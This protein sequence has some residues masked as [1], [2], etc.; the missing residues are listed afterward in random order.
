[1]VPSL[2]VV[3]AEIGG[4]PGQAV[5]VDRGTIV[6]VGDTETVDRRGAEVVD[7]GGG[8]LLP[9]LHDHHLHL[10]GLA[11]RM[12]SIDLGPSTTPDGAD[13]VLCSAVE[14][15]ERGPWI[16]VAG[17][18]EHRHGPLDRRRLDR[19]VGPQ[20][21]RVQHRSGLAWIVSTAGMAALG[22]DP[23]PGPG[24]ARGDP[25]PD[26]RP[27]GRC[28]ESEDPPVA[29]AGVERRS[30]GEATGWLLRVD[31]W[32]G[33]RI[34]RVPPDLAPVGRQL[35]AWGITG[36]TDTTP[37]LDDGATGLLRQACERGSLPQQLMVLGRPDADG[38]VGWAELGPVK[39]VADEQVGLDVDRLAEVI[40]RAH[41]GGRAVAVHCV[42]RAECV[43][44]VV[45]LALA[46][47]RTGDRLEHASVLPREFDSRLAE[48]GVTV[49]AQPSFVAER[50]DHYLA[51]VD[52]RDHPDLHRLASLMTAG[53]RLGF[54]S[55]APVATA[56][57]WAAMAA[58]HERRTPS[59]RVLGGDEALS[60][61]QALAG[62]LGSPHDPG[63]P[64]RRIEPG[65]PAD[66]CLLHVP[67]VAALAAPSA[68]VV[69]AT[70]VAGRVVHG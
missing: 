65:A 15:A 33:D 42:T 24:A 32:L 37:V 25:F 1:M 26:L 66:L 47:T 23:G 63:G 41:V 38:L 5:R 30:D 9:G 52:P 6:A 3:D 48:G 62:F 16:R 17:F 45:A 39:L 49:V 61:V 59:R 31:R 4:R 68:E 60:P 2:V 29:T 19:L 12:G 14:V 51:T 7:A 50:G 36:V 18:D 70:A 8:A 67:L 58:A 22:L 64:A 44:A 46:G 27:G 53:V 20:P 55:D 56:D 57:P 54:G 35:A 13:R 10:L 69:R 28:V 34:G 43:A 21:V 11:A 40:R